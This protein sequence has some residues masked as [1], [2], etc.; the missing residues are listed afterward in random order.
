MTDL[1]DGRYSVSY[2]PIAPG[3]FIVSVA[4]AGSPIMG[5]PFTLDVKNQPE[6]RKQVSS[7]LQNQD[8]SIKNW[9]KT[10]KFVI[11]P[12]KHKRLILFQIAFSDTISSQ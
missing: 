11:L 4:V 6:I 10:I 5:S 3:K 9:K 2:A 12:A 8:Y 7:L 1:K